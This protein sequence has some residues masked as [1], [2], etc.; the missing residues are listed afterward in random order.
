[1]QKRGLSEVVAAILLVLLA[2]AAV[3]IVWNIV[4]KNIEKDSDTGLITTNL[5]IKK[6]E[7]SNG[8]YIIRLRRETG[9][10]KIIKLKFVFE[11]ST[12]SQVSGVDYSIEELEEKTFTVSDINLSNVTKISVYPVIKTP[13]GNE[14]LGPLK[15]IY[16][17]EGV[18]EPGISS[19]KIITLDSIT[20]KEDGY[21][22]GYDGTNCVGGYKGP[23]CSAYSTSGDCNANYSSGPGPTGFVTCE[24]TGGEFCDYASACGA[25]RHN[26]DDVLYAGLAFQYERSY[27]GWNTSSIPDTATIT[28]INFTFYVNE[29]T[30]TNENLTI[31]SMTGKKASDYANN[32][33]ENGY[34]WN[35]INTSYGILASEIINADLDL[36]QPGWHSLILSSSANTYMKNQLSQDYFMIGLYNPVMMSALRIDSSEGTHKPYLIVTYTA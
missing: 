12:K 21:L 4:K 13:K 25:S 34:F 31:I 2:V 30:D 17:F 10:G 19:E 11:N 16:K 20:I 36:G 26:A 6:V 27:I 8:N 29:G 9:Q 15:D 3:I 23:A 28:E 33:K 14:I 7:F 22:T 32:G 35:N 18:A 5:D 1:M 24:W